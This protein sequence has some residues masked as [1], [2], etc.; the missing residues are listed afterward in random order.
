M[1]NTFR[2]KSWVIALALLAAVGCSKDKDVTSLDAGGDGNKQTAKYFISAVVDGATYAMAVK[3]LEKDTT[4]TTAQAIEN[5]LTFTHYAYNGTTAALALNYQ[6]GNPSPGIIFQLDASG[7]LKKQDEF[8][9]QNSFNTIGAADKYLITAGNGKTLTGSN[10]GKIGSIFYFIDLA[11]NNNILE[12]AIVTEK[13][14]NNNRADFVGIVDAGNK[15]FLTGLMVTDGSPDSVYVAKLDDNLNVKKIYRDGRLSYSAGQMKSARYAQIG[16]DASGNTYVFSG[17]Y[18]ATTTK[19]AGAL[20]IKKGEDNFD[21]SYHFDIETA[22]G[23]YRF[24]KVWHITEDYFLLELY[25]E[26]GAPGS[27]AAAT[28]Y[29]IAKMSTKQFTWV[30]SAFPD[31]STI[32][33]AGWPFTADGKAYI[34]VTTSGGQPT[35]YVV[36]PKTAVA[37]KGISVSG[38]TSIAGLAKLTP[39]K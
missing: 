30:S 23:G 2:N 15:E 35:V 20:L 27:S 5:R 8:V 37:K 17:A 12:K 1:K 10:D 36:D 11:N 16:N 18:S 22:T 3:D 39:Q 9:L 28:Q 25:N 19:K 24:R 32:D 6:Q 33:S 29:G 21:S 4:I 31:K 34:P 38:V 13:L 7:A 26:T 14:I